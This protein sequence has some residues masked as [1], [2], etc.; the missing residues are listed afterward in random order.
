MEGKG[1]KKKRETYAVA[2]QRTAVHKLFFP[3]SVSDSHEPACA[4]SCRGWGVRPSPATPRD[5]QSWAN[6]PMQS[7]QLRIG[8]KGIP[9]VCRGLPG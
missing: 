1:K 6:I 8:G 3:P 9:Q 7:G 5:G 2:K 4:I